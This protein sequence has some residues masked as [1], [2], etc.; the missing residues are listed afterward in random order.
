MTWIKPGKWIP[1]HLCALISSLISKLLS[2]RQKYSYNV[3]RGAYVI[4]STFLL[5]I[6][7]LSA[8]PASRSTKAQPKNKTFAK[9]VH[10]VQQKTRNGAIKFLPSVVPTASTASSSPSPSSSRQS[11]QPSTYDMM[12]VDEVNLSQ[13]QDGE[14]SRGSK[15]SKKWVPILIPL[16][17][18]IDCSKAYAPSLTSWLELRNQCLAILLQQEGLIQS[19]CHHCHLEG[20][21]YRCRDCFGSPLCCKSCLL[22]AHVQISVA[23]TRLVD[24]RLQKS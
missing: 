1:L 5:P 7:H 4:N 13:N 2:W 19:H 12:V 11:M 20:K 3:H 22:Q 15:K 17:M 14:L 16:A 6:H 18:G 24:S 10:F 8:M 21:M 23:A 9:E